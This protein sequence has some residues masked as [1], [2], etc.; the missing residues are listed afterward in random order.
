M[1]TRRRELLRLLG[2]LHLALAAFAL[3]ALVLDGVDPGE[4]TPVLLGAALGVG[5]AALLLAATRT[6][7][8]PAV[9]V[10]VGLAGLS[11]ALLLALVAVEPPA[12]QGFLHVALVWVGVLAFAYLTVRQAWAHVVVL[13]VGAAVVEGVDGVPPAELVVAGLLLL[14]TTTGVGLLLRHLV[15]RADRLAELDELTGALNRR[16]LQSRAAPL[17]LA[18]TG[19]PHGLLALDLD[20]FKEL[21]DREGHAAGDEALR[22]AVQRWR[23]VLRPS[24]LLARVGGDEF[25]VVLPGAGLEQATSTA[26]RLRSSAPPGVS[27]SVGVAV[28]DGGED[29]SEAMRRADA[30]LYAAKRG[31]G[32]APRPRRRNGYGDAPTSTTHPERRRGAERRQG[33]RRAAPRRGAD[34]RG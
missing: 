32:P 23:T 16:G 14:G 33:E 2:A 22:A 9:L 3:V 15:D 34:R 4:P 11:A 12:A 26:R 27:V 21:N 10:H 30:D 13:V 6:D 7:R 25:V 8:A 19:G 18:R 5:L 31:P 28:L 20:G 29:L 17:A 24:D 1:T